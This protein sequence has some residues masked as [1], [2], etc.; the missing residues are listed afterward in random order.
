MSPMIQELY[1]G[2]NA[3]V[4]CN[5]PVSSVFRERTEIQTEIH[6]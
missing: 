4:F 1:K 3:E 5:L 2:A 6:F